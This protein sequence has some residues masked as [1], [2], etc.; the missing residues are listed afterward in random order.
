MNICSINEINKFALSLTT[1]N[2]G[3][4]QNKIDQP[5]KYIGV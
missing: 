4:V 1:M 3:S 2:V 5:H